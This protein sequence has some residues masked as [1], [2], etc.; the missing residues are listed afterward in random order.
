MGAD[1]LLD[2]SVGVAL[3]GEPLSEAELQEVL[4]SAGG[5]EALS[6]VLRGVP[7]DFPASIV[8]GSQFNSS[9]LDDMDF[10]SASGF[11]HYTTA[12]GTG[13]IVAPAVSSA[14]FW[15]SMKSAPRSS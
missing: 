15:A 10:A 2:F 8:V 11:L 6:T 5:L 3:D 7:D 14:A 12:P 9:G 1:A 13:R 4:A